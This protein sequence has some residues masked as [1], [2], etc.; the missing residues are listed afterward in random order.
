MLCEIRASTELEGRKSGR[1]EGRNDK[2]AVVER[3]YVLPILSDVVELHGLADVDKHRQICHQ[4]RPS[5][6][7]TTPPIA[8]QV[9]TLEAKFTQRRQA[10][11]L[12]AASAG[13]D[14]QACAAGRG[15]RS[16]QV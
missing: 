7:P 14:G 4:R 6:H 8:H 2:M 16:Q 13:A 1:A 10:D 12:S 9:Y 3:V 5:A 15:A 11:V